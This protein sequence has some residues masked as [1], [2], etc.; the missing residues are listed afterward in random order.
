[1]KSFNSS[2]NKSNKRTKN[3]KNAR[4]KHVKKLH[5]QPMQVQH[6]FVTNNGEYGKRTLCHD[7]G[8][9]QIKL[10]FGSCLR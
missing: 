10:Y 8:S 5:G 3:K 7:V 4:K 2:K 1:M 9:K 6:I